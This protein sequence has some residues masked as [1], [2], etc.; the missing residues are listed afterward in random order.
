MSERTTKR[1]DA[2]AEV[3]VEVGLVEGGPADRQVQ[4]GQIQLLERGIDDG[5]VGDGERVE[6]SWVHP[7]AR[8]VHQVL[9]SSAALRHAPAHKLDDPVG[10]QALGDAP[11]Q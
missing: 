1:A 2:L 6:R 11:V 9:S 10:H 5:H 8:A 7:E 3:S 4:P